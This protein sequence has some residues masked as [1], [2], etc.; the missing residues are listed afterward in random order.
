MGLVDD[1]GDGLVGEED[2]RRFLRLAESASSKLD[3]YLGSAYPVPLTGEAITPA[4]LDADKDVLVY[5]L[6]DDGDM[7]SETVEKRYD[8]ALRWA[9]DVACK[10]AQLGETASEPPPRISGV[11]RQGAEPMLTRNKVRSLL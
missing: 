5:L 1:D 7:M 2:E 4:V 9:R 10:K 8:A 3:S 6:S 11:R